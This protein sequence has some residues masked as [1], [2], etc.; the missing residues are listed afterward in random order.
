MILLNRENEKIPTAP[1]STGGLCKS[2]TCIGW[3]AP[4]SFL[5]N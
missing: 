1:F 5:T 2:K 4:C 3:Q